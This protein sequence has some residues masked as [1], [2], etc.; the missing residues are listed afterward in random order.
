MV[1]PGPEGRVHSFRRCASRVTRVLPRRS[2]PSVQHP[3]KTADDMGATR[4]TRRSMPISCLARHV[5]PLWWSALLCGCDPALSRVFER[6]FA[7]PSS[8]PRPLT[9]AS[10][11]T[12]L[13]RSPVTRSSRTSRTASGWPPPVTT[14]PRRPPSSPGRSVP[15]IARSVPTDRPARFVDRPAR[16]DRLGP[17]PVGRPPDAFQRRPERP[18]DRPVRSDGSAGP[19]RR[20]ARAV[21]GSPRSVRRTTGPSVRRPS[22]RRPSGR[23]TTARR[24]PSGR[25]GVTTPRGAGR[26]RY[27]C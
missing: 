23:R 14:S 22:G 26:P 10:P 5:R 25:S 24:A 15:R 20:S 16:S 2:D 4:S 18:A 7:C 9:A 13:R 27:R 21:D 11:P 8:T 19:F 3:L 6:E 17:P 1:G 12:G